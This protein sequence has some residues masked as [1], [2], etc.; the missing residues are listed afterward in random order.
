MPIKACEVASPDCS[1]IVGE[2]ST[3][4]CK[5]Q[6]VKVCTLK[7]RM[8]K[9]RRVRDHGNLRRQVLPPAATLHHLAAVLLILVALLIWVSMNVSYDG[10][11]VGLRRDLLANL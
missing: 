7:W 2:G 6:Q 3:I 10:R 1:T 4:C 9:R 5:V 8:G 11:R